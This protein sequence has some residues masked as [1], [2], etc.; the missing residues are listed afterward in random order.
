MMNDEYQKSQ[1]DDIVVEKIVHN[2]LKS[3][4]DDI[5][6]TIV[7]STTSMKKQYHPYGILE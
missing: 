2:F 1:R 7:N 6:V 4:R 3:Q 5:M